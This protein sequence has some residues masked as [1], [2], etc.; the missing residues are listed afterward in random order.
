MKII[1]ILI[2][3]AGFLVGTGNAF[4]GPEKVKICHKGKTINI[5]RNAIQAH[6]GHGDQR[7]A[8]KKVPRA[9][10]LL[11]C[12]GLGPEIPISAVSL[13]MGVPNEIVI[14]VGESCS[15]SIAFL[16]NNGFIPTY[17]NSVFNS[18]LEFLETIHVL[19]GPMQTIPE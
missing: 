9:V 17:E 1:P 4:A 13:S 14:A 3:L 5:S 19:T 12:G 8:C 11:R 16:I 10:A 7:K 15:E 6:V 18:S 2:M